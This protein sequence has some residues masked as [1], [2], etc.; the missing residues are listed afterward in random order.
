MLA[1]IFEL[2]EFLNATFLPAVINA[3][4][5]SE[6]RIFS[7]LPAMIMFQFLLRIECS[8]RRPFRKNLEMKKYIK[9]IVSP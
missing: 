7:S 6:E 1:N 4:T 3:P 9:K 2:L 8:K 5:Q